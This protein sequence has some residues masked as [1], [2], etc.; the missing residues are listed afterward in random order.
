MDVP[1][2]KRLHISGLTPSITADDLSKRFSVFGNV[3]SVDGIGALNGVGLPRNFAYVTIDTTAGKLAKCMNVLS[4][5]TWKGTKLKL[6]EAKPEYKERLAAERAAFEN[7][8]DQPPRKRRR[9]DGV[10]AQDMSLVTPEIANTKGGWKVT[11]MGRILRPM[12]MRPA[13][14]LPPTLEEQTRNAALAKKNQKMDKK[15]RF[16]KATKGEKEKKK[17]K[18]EPV[19]RARI[20]TIDVT[21]WGSTQLKGIFLE[22]QGAVAAR[23]PE[24]TEEAE[25]S[26]SSGEEVVEEDEEE[27]EEAEGQSE[28]EEKESKA[29]GALAPPQSSSPISASPKALPSALRPSNDENDLSLEKSKALNLL[30]SLF[31]A[32]D[33]DEDDWMGK[34]SVG[35]DVDEEELLKQ[36]QR[37]LKAG[38]KDV[39]FELVPRDGDKRRTK[40]SV[41]PQVQE[42][43]GEDDEVLQEPVTE[44]EGRKEEKTEEPPRTAATALK[45]LFAPREE[46][47]GFSLLGHLDLDLEL[48]EELGFALG[49]DVQ[50]SVH[51]PTTLTT[52]ADL[53][54]ALHLPPSTTITATPRSSI[55]HINPKEPLFFPHSL[56]PDSNINITNKKPHQKDPFDL[57]KEKKLVLARPGSS[58]L[59]N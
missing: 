17:R 22:S 33:S 10:Y 20:R 38:Q 25:D 21:K 57:V 29:V 56:T 50:D 43:E 6:G 46:E 58:V 47:G 13:R 19:K 31:A 8:S 41:A 32:N 2:T 34:E 45:D 16:G 59:Q 4:G 30:S 37:P 51:A 5:S 9:V 15:S 28:S 55:A 18:K 14:P 12:R 49:G 24:A 7:T 1:V 26:D 39:D 36:H 40:V 11:P 42:D 23:R 48:D 53:H 27:E 54:P 52:A 44:E 35:S 3:Q